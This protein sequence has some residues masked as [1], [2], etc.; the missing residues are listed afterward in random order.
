ME[1]SKSE[2][3]TR[4]YLRVGCPICGRQR[5][6]WRRG[7]HNPMW[8]YRC[9]K[10]HLRFYGEQPRDINRWFLVTRRAMKQRGQEAI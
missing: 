6:F 1:G 5:W 7:G 9:G 2:K 3:Y 4:A 10:C 8:H